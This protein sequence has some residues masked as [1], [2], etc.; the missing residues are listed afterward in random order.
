MRPPF[1]RYCAA[2][3]IVVGACTSATEPRVNDTGGFPYRL[4]ANSVRVFGTTHLIVLPMQF[5]DGASPPVTRQALAQSLFAPSNGGPVAA[6]FNLASGGMFTLRG[7][8]GNWSRSTVR[9]DEL[10]TRGRMA[11]TR[12]GDY[13]LEAIQAADASIDFGQYDDDGPDGFPNSGDDDGLVDG[14]IVVMNSDRNTYCDNDLSHG[15]HPNT[16]TRWVDSTGHPFSTNDRSARGGKIGIRGYSLMS[17]VACDG[18]SVPA[19]TLAHEL[20]H[21]LFQLPD[22]YHAVSTA[23]P[24]WTARRWIVGCWELMAAGSDWGC[25]S[26][27]PHYGSTEMAAFGA[28]TRTLIGWSTPTIIPNDRDSTYT[29]HALGS[30]GTVLQIPIASGEFL[31]VEYR[32]PGP[33]D[34]TPPAAGVLI[35]HVAVDLPYYPPV[36]GPREYKVSLIEADD[37]GALLRTDGEGGDRGVAADAFGV[38]RSELVPGSHSGAVAINGT[39]FPFSLREIVIDRAN[40]IARFRVAPR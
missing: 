19:N 26:G 11:P 25:G 28:W 16:N 31:L 35:Y 14:G 7:D 22:L 32:E 20:G 39:P 12:D 34:V 29:L 2:A 36:D 9:H 30:G 17:A 13:V 23:I 21:L 18:H 5:A 27:T 37:N 8:V 33:I 3:L 10:G 1:I 38:L 24:R 6:L 15:L 4:S 40:H